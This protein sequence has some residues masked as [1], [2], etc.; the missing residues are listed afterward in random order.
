MRS[1]VE[2]HLQIALRRCRLAALDV[3]KDNGPN[4]MGHRGPGGCAQGQ[5]R[6]ENNPSG[7][8]GGLVGH[9][10]RF[11]FPPKFPKD[12]HNLHHL[13]VGLF[14]IPGQV[15]VPQCI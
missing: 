9:G 12:T 2:C 14:A 10:R 13:F 1:R 4:I 6:P 5:G 7:W 3:K 8:L 11:G 15:V